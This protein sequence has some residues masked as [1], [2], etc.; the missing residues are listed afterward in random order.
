MNEIIHAVITYWP[1]IAASYSRQEIEEQVTSLIERL[2]F[3]ALMSTKE[4]I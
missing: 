2:Q 4:D 3:A 1:A